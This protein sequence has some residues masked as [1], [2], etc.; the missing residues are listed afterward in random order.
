MDDINFLATIIGLLAAVITL[1]SVLMKIW[2]DNKMLKDGL[3]KTYDAKELELK[4]REIDNKALFAQ[5]KLELDR[6][7][8]EAR[9][10]WK[11]AEFGLK[12]IDLIFSHSNEDEEEYD[13]KEVDE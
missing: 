2:Y 8:H 1:V 3:R 7:K 10:K 11:N 13:E 12:L 5:Q 4:Q 9:E 6:R